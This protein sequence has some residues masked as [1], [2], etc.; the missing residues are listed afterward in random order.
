MKKILAT[1]A[2]VICALGVNAQIPLMGGTEENPTEIKIGEEY[3]FPTDFSNAYFTF[4]SQTDGVLYLSMS[5]SLKI[6]DQDGPLPLIGKQCVKGIHAGKTYTFYNTS[7]WGDSITM[8]PNFVEGKPYLPIE[9]VSTSLANGATY[10]TTIHNGDITFCFNTGLNTSAIKA[11][12][13][14]PDGESITVNNYR[15]SKDYN[16]QGSNYVLQLA[17]TYNALL[18]EGKL[19]AQDSFSVVLSN[20]ISE[21]NSEN[22][23]DGKVT[24]NLKASGEAV[25][26]ISISHQEKLQSYYM[27]G[28]DAG[29]I[30]LTFSAPVTCQAKNATLSYGDREAGTWTE[31]KVPYTIEGNTITWNVQ[32][33]HL[34]QV[35]AN[36]EGERYVSISLKNICDNEGTPV[37]SNTAGTIG[38]ILFSYLIE[39]M[40][41][42]IY[43]DFQPIAGSNIDQTKEVEIW[44]SA[45]KY[46]TFSGA[47]VTYQKDGVRTEENI[48]LNQ[49][50]QENDPYSETDLL[51]YVPIETLMCDAGEVTIELTE[52]LAANGTQPDIKVT[53]TSTGKGGDSIHSI[54]TNATSVVAT[55]QLDGTPIPNNRP[56]KGV[57]LQK[58]TNGEI[59]KTVVTN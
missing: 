5:K 56:R 37:E 46:I 15:T 35:P 32:G 40:D 39:N 10:R 55:Y 29:L 23:Y 2:M 36:S 38:T 50:R 59:K 9:L 42:N 3:L 21:T 25:K 44:I 16:T 43:P 13:I 11:E 49:L 58:L 19:K 34:T 33:I 48:P 27:P 52:V 57:Y 6:F 30:V 4:H 24:L 7:T 45:G 1:L 12:V 28:D 41:I 26:L 20:I 54:P 22:I 51:V 17:E 14:L 53:Y 31:V 8:T 47:K 18:K